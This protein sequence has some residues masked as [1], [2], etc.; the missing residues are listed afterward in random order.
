MGKRPMIYAAAFCGFLLG[1]CAG[2]GPG[3]TGND[4]GGIFPWSPESRIHARQIA[5]DHCAR[6]YKLAHINAVVPGYGN[7]ISF[8]CRFD[9]RY[10]H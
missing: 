5:A 7:Y 8:S 1:G 2:P 3:V 10:S 4:T 6:Y 9:R